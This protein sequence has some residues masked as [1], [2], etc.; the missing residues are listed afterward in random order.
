MPKSGKQSIASLSLDE[1]RRLVAQREQVLQGLQA[2]E[3]SLAKELESVRHQIAVIS[4]RKAGMPASV[5]PA[6]V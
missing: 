3:Q 1:L 6:G 4:G 5:A 2:R